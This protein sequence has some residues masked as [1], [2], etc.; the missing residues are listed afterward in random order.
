MATIEQIT[1][2][3]RFQRATPEQRQR[4]IAKA[5][6]AP[7][8]FKQRFMGVVS[9]AQDASGAS[10]YG[11]MSIPTAPSNPVS[12]ALS[13]AK[14]TLTAPMRMGA[15]VGRLPSATGEVI[16]EEGGR[17]FP[18]HATAAAALGTLVSVLPELIMAYKGIGDLKSMQNPVIK[19]LM[20]TPKELGPEYAAQDAAIGVERS[21]PLEKGDVPRYPDPYQHPSNLIKPRYSDVESPAPK[22]VNTSGKVI[23][24][25]PLSSVEPSESTTMTGFRRPKPTIPAE[26]L[27]DVTPLSYPKEPANFIKYADKKLDAFGNRLNP[28]ELMDWRVKLETDMSSGKIPKF[29]KDISGKETEKITTAFQE[30]S[31]LSSRIGKVFNEIADTELGGVKLPKN[32]SPTRTGLN[33]ANTIANKQEAV[34]AA[35]K[36]YGKYGVIG[37]GGTMLAKSIKDEIFPSNR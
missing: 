29:K 35:L 6:N 23:S 30:A 4:L 26:P 21:V 34:K 17:A 27:P 9:E 25:T 7:P 16:A 18:E 28:Q 36:K 3:P 13:A 33:K 37:V 11:G 2:D 31:K 14:E 5:E 24:P 1:S 20:N 19:G 15:T 22:I 8:S 10:P 12:G 32:V